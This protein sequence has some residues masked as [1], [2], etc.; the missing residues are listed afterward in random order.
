MFI[1]FVKVVGVKRIVV[2]LLIMKNIEKINFKILVVMDI[3]GV[4]EIY[5]IGGV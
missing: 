2:C 3:V 5:V 4:D 1:I